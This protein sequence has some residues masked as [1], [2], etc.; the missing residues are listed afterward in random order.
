MRFAAASR[1]RRAWYGPLPKVVVAA[2]GVL[3]ALSSS[4]QADRDNDADLW[5][6]VVQSLARL[7]DGN[8][9]RAESQIFIAL[10]AVVIAVLVLFGHW[11]RV[12]QLVSR[13]RQ[14]QTTLD[15]RERIA[16]ELHDTLLQGTQALVLKVH[17]ASKMAAKDEPLHQMLEQVM[18]QATQAMLE[19]RDRVQDL[20]LRWSSGDDFATLLVRFGQDLAQGDG[21]SFHA[22]VEGCARELSPAAQREVGLIG[23]EALLNAFHHSDARMIE[24]QID[25]TGGHFQL[26]VRDDGIG[27]DNDALSRPVGGSRWGI[28]GMQARARVISSEIR[29][30]SRR[31]AGT[32]VQLRVPH[33]VAYARPQPRLR[34]ELLRTLSGYRA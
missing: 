12:R 15:E 11:W 2:S 28:P 24:L 1:H 10:C 6:P 3:L 30:W 32:E 27:F 19:A 13:N 8:L 9:T 23:R 17:V 26:T 7:A 25:F 16:H 33:G 18:A 4:A 20:Q 22:F 5:G 34:R 29:I 21:P 31:S 14:L